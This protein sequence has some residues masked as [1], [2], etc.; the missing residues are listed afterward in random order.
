MREHLKLVNLIAGKLANVRVEGVQTGHCIFHLYLIRRGKIMLRLFDCLVSV[1]YRVDIGLHRGGMLRF[2]ILCVEKLVRILVH[3]FLSWDSVGHGVI[4][5][6]HVD[7]LAQI[8]QFQDL[9][10]RFELCIAIICSSQDN[11]ASG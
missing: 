3:L 4:L 10:V 11:I 8:L 1:C 7:V 6:V 9:W 2:L 5:V